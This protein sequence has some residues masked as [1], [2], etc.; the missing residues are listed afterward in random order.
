MSVSSGAGNNQRGRHHKTTIGQA[1]NNSTLSY[2]CD[3]GIPGY[4]GYIPTSLSVPLPQKPNPRLPFDTT[5]NPTDV[6][7]LLLSL[8][9]R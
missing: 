4:T 1:G 3:I 9:A 6:S 2:R 8:P 7:A 5:D